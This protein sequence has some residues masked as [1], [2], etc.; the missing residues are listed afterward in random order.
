MQLLT[1]MAT[2]PR[3]VIPESLTIGIGMSHIFFLAL[4]SNAY[5]LP[6]RV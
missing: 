5:V 4:V 2:D 3:E 6:A 1:K